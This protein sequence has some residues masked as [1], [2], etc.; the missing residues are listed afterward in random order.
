MP[1]HEIDEQQLQA[2]EQVCLASRAGERA[3]ATR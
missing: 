1:P 2:P 3:G